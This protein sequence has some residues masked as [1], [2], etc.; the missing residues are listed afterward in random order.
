MQSKR[1]ASL[2]L[3]IRLSS[4]S[5][6]YNLAAWQ[7]V[8]EKYTARKKPIILHSLSRRRRDRAG[9]ST[10]LVV[11]GNALQVGAEA[12]IGNC[13]WNTR[14]TLKYVL[15]SRR[16]ARQACS[17]CHQRRSRSGS[18]HVLSRTCR[19][20]R[21]GSGP[22]SCYLLHRDWLPDARSGQSP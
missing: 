13:T 20:D 22:E 18:W 1:R 17:H 16:H 10:V 15:P 11:V 2:A 14:N 8:P 6:S 12:Y 9:W 21:A 19:A 5:T 7:A 3:R 4:G